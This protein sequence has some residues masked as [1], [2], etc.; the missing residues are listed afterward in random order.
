L[1]FYKILLSKITNA[2]NHRLF[3]DIIGYDH[4]KRLFG[5]T[6]RSE[7]AIHILLVGP[8]ASAKTMFLTSLMT[9]LKNS[10]F[11][12]GANSTKAGMIGYLFEYRPRY[13]LVDEIDKMCGK[14]QAFLLNLMETGIVSES[15]YRKNRSAQM[16][17]SVF[18]TINNIKKISA[19]L[20]S[21]FFIVNLEPYTYEQFIET[22]EQ[23]LAR[24]IEEGLANIIAEAVWKK[25]QDI[26]DCVKIGT[27][28]KSHS[29]L[30]FI[31]SNFLK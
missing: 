27:M 4:I 1:K 18:A 22:T 28:A 3:E 16:K 30:E 5:M 11:A 15:K 25:S 17:V 6:L 20:R 19:P 29:D 14:D 26:R 9:Q 7:S 24:R 23:L 2:G 21:R 10:Y 12:D 31:L 13:L 8:P